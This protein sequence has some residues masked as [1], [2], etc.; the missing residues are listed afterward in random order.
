MAS[1]YIPSPYT[2][3]TGGVATGGSSLTEEEYNTLLPLLNDINR[4]DIL[5]YGASGWEK[6]AAGASGQLLKSNGEATDPSWVST[7]VIKGASWVGGGNPLLASANKVPV[8]CEV[9]GTINKVVILTNGGIGS[10]EIDIWKKSASSYP[11]DVSDSITASDKPS[12]SGGS[13]LIK[14]TFTGWTLTVTAGDCLEFV[15]NSTSAFT[16]INIFVEIDKQ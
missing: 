3:L 10:C 15:L 11:P 1:S 4:G 7:K 13:S 9:S 14:S 8:Y 2:R 12:I 16:E 5:Y 6:L